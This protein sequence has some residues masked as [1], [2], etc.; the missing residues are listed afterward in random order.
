[1]NERTELT[2]S[3]IPERVEQQRRY[4]RTAATLDVEFRLTQLKKLRALV[5][6]NE[7]EL[8]KAIHR[9]FEKSKHH[10]QLTEIFPLYFHRQSTGREDRQRGGRASFDQR[11]PGTRRKNPAIFATETQTSS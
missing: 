9:D 8:H 6:A 7:D 4:F 11:H 3:E 2:P 10:N 1:M 5:Q